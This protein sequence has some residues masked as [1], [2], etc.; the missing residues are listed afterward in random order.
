MAGILG[1]PQFLPPSPDVA[2]IW[3]LPFEI[4]FPELHKPW[5][6]FR[7]LHGCAPCRE[8]RRY[9]A[10]TP[11]SPPSSFFLR[12]RAVLLRF[13][14]PFHTLLHH[15]LPSGARLSPLAPV[16]GLQ[17]TGHIMHPNST[18]PPPPFM[19]FPAQSYL[20]FDIYVFSG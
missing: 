13:V 20:P 15:T 3:S 6:P 14:L 11:F 19:A 1:G 7:R 2:P 9:S 17:P 18:P 16:S 5:F 10:P 12:R 8:S 4:L